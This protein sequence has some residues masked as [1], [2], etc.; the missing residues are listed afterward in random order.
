MPNYEYKCLDCGHQFEALMP[1]GTEQTKCLEC[2]KEEAQKQ[3]S[4][5]GV[6]FIGSGFYKTDSQKK[7]EAPK[8]EGGE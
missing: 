6:K 2:G 3:L 8:S 7:P 1:A 4:A 5:P